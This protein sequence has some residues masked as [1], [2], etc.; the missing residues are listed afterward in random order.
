MTQFKLKTVFIWFVTISLLIVIGLSSAINIQQFSGFYY[1]KFE[2]QHLPDAIENVTEQ[3]FAELHPIIVTANNMASNSMVQEWIQAGETRSP[4]HDSIIR[5]LAQQKQAIGADTIFFTSAKSLN[6]YTDEGLFKTLEPKNSHDQWFYQLLQQDIKQEVILDMSEVTRELT[7]FVNSVVT[8]QGQ[9]LGV[10]GL[11]YN[12]TQV[13]RMISEYQLGETGFLFL[14]DAEGR[15]TVHPDTQWIGKNIQDIPGYQ[16][17]ASQLEQTQYHPQLFETRIQGEKVYIATRQVGSTNFSLVGVQPKQEIAGA[18]NQTIVLTLF[19][20]VLVTVVF[21]ILTVFFSKAL[22]QRIYRV[23]DELMSMSQAGGDLSRRLDDTHDNELGHLAKGFNAV[24]SKVSDILAKIEQTEREIQHNVA[25]MNR[26]TED[27]FHA[28]DMQKEQ[29][30]LVA[31]A[32]TEM[33][34]TIREIIGIAH[35]TDDDTKEASEETLQTNKN[36]QY[37][38]QIMTELNGIMQHIEST[39]DEFAQNAREISSVMDEI[40]GISEQTNLLALNAAIEAARAGEQGRGFSVVA[41][42]VRT[43]AQRTQQSTH[44]ISQQVQQLQQTAVEST[45]AITSGIENSQRVVENT[46]LAVEALASIN[47]RF[48]VITDGNHQLATATEE[49]GTVVEHIHESATSI[50][51]GANTIHQNAE[52][53]LEVVQS[54]SEQAAILKELLEQFNH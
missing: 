49:Q 44:T 34:E 12:A 21:I 41:D 17:V 24:I 10:T 15:I 9:T 29:T 27:T 3:V 8:A 31:T 48:R 42:E 6:Y 20:A 47:E 7:I 39:V 43:L 33:G 46:Q 26:I 36:M 13:A 5:F 22:S 16:S 50:S 28:T 45:Q 40:D 4:Q 35:R 52:Q 2:E 23:G 14:I 30:V 32:I 53:Q 37:I 51:T 38:A 54:L 25:Q 1:G 18:I 19:V 11:G